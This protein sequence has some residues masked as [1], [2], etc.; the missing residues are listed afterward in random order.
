[1]LQ[2]PEKARSPEE[3]A[4]I[5]S[6]VIAASFFIYDVLFAGGP[7]KNYRTSSEAVCRVTRSV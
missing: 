6:R 3:E 2:V 7:K 4:V 5:A 1:L